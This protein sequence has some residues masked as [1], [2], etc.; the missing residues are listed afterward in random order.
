MRAPCEERGADLFLLARDRA[1][2]DA[3]TAAHLAACEGCREELVH[4]RRLAGALPAASRGLRPRPSTKTD[5]MKE[6]EAALAAE[7]AAPPP[8]R[9]PYSRR[10]GESHALHG[11]RPSRKALRFRSSACRN[12]AA[13]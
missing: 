6:V 1:E 9:A 11:A 13:S 7:E 5:L 12:R 3:A 8:R 2:P 10:G 4:L